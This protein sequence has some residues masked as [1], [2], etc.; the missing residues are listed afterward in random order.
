MML[1]PEQQRMYWQM[2]LAPAG[3]VLYQWLQFFASL[4]SQAEAH[5][6][7]SMHLPKKKR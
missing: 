1:T 2:V 4:A 6:R 7:A 3:V 5:R